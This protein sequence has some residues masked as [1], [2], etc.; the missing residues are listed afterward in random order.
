M[1]TDDEALQKRAAEAFELL[2]KS[3]SRLLGRDA[4]ARLA[5]STV[6]QQHFTSKEWDALAE[7]VAVLTLSQKT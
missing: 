3:R 4:L 7:L 6:G 1:S 5:N 2:R